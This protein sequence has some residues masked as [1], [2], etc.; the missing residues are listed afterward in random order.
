VEAPAPLGPDGKAAP[1]SQGPMRPNFPKPLVSP[2]DLDELDF[3][4]VRLCPGRNTRCS[5]SLQR[6]GE[7][8]TGRKRQDIEAT[9]G[10]VCNT[11]RRTRELL[12]EAGKVDVAVIGF[13]G[14]PWTL[15][16][17]MVGEMSGGGGGVF[18]KAKKWLYSYPEASLRLLNGISD[19]VA[20]FLIAQAKAGAHMVQVRASAGTGASRETT[21]LRGFT[22]ISGSHALRNVDRIRPSNPIALSGLRLL[23]WRAV[24]VRL[25]ALGA[26]GPPT[27]RRDGPGPPGAVKRPRHFPK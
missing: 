3:N 20:Q 22:I 19:V 4:P 14:G 21:V 17:Y 5:C 16:T 10:F 12:S 24:A 11:V 2:A 8:L 7:L 1:Q 23:G 15:M 18:A 27:H 13:T 25:R 6:T 9:L 26:A